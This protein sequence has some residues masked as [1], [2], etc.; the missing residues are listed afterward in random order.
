[1]HIPFLKNDT[2]LKQKKSDKQETKNQS[3]KFIKK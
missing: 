2:Q 3:P 1:M